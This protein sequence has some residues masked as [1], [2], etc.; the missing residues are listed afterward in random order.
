MQSTHELRR[1]IA[2]IEE[3]RKIT[4]AMQLVSSSRLK[5]VLSHIEHNHRYFLGVQ[6]A[7]R[8]ILCSPEVVRHKYLDLRDGGRHTYI[9]VAGEKGLCG[10]Y[11]SAVLDLAWE[12]MRRDGAS[13]SIIAVGSVA[14]EYFKQRGVTPDIEFAGMMQEI[15]ISDAR[16]LAEELFSMY[17][18]ELTDEVDIVY[19]SFHGETRGKPIVRRLLPVMREDQEQTAASAHA[20][21]IQYEPSGQALF[22]LLVPQYVIGILFGAL[23]Q[24]YAAEHFARMNAMS[25]ATDNADELI[26]KLNLQYH[27]ARQ[28]AITNELLESVSST[29]ASR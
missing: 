16:E 15:D 25:S 29:T 21:D 27:M 2:A 8:D 4:N 11:N 18:Q 7:M 14:G 24:A 28:S 13:N 10:D 23:T 6:G 9:V 12:T 20:E 22:T 19:T 3:T 26:K 5:R 17:D 1:H